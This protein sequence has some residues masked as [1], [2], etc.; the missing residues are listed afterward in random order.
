[1]D[2]PSSAL[3]QAEPQ[4]GS[5]RLV[6]LQAAFDRSAEHR[7]D[8]TAVPNTSGAISA[9]GD[10][11]NGINAHENKAKEEVFSLRKDFVM[12]NLQKR[13]NVKKH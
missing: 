10:S 3:R 13:T 8:E 5:A 9:A 11:S 2:A 1:N 6:R 12:N 4:R 7:S